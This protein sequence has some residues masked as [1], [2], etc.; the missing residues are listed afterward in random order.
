VRL[1]DIKDEAPIARVME[2]GI[3]LETGEEIELDTIIYATGFDA[4]MGPILAVDFQ[5]VNGLKPKDLWANGPQTFLGF[6]V[7]G[8]PNMT[9]VRNRW[10]ILPI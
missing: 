10:D 7:K 3:L 2:K 1:I 8:F 6:L 5:G 9:M 4:G